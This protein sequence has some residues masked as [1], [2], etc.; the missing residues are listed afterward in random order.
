MVCTRI[1]LQRKIANFAWLVV[2]PEPKDRQYRGIMSNA[3][4]AI[5]E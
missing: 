5:T 1:I 2:K 3:H 4:F